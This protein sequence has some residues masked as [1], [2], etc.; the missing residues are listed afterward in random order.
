MK[1]GEVARRTGLRP[2]TLRYYER[3]GLLPPPARRSRRRLY[4]DGVF[5]RIRM[6][7]I[8]RAAG[9]TIA[10]TR[11]FLSGFPSG[12]APSA[13]WRALAAR[14]REELD[15]QIADAAAMKAIL[16]EHFRCACATIAD[17]EAGLAR[18]RC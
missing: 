8:A 17:C 3:A 11:R 10:E 15:R 5:G 18:R 12:T 4:D 16:D 14:K 9:F 2:S 7:Q 6:I 1:I 13:R